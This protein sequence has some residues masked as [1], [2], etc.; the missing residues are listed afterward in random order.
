MRAPSAAGARL[1]HPTSANVGRDT[2]RGPHLHENRFDVPPDYAA[3]R[4][5]D[6]RPDDGQRWFE[7]KAPTQVTKKGTRTTPRAHT[8]SALMVP[9]MGKGTMDKSMAKGFA[10]VKQGMEAQHKAGKPPTA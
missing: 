6:V 7:S 10:K 3:K 9:L 5:T 2:R 4:L 8:P 1:S